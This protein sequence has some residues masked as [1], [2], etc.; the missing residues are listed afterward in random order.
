MEDLIFQLCN[1][2]KQE[3]KV[4][5]LDDLEPIA[6]N[7]AT[8]YPSECPLWQYHQDLTLQK[9]SVCEYFFGQYQSTLILESK[10]SRVLELVY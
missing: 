2:E 4:L 7:I 1:S 8:D 3:L 10:E 9:Q 5:L 6:E